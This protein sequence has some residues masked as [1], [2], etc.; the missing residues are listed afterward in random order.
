MD[1]NGHALSLARRKRAYRE[2]IAKADI[3]HADGG[4][5]VTLSHKLKGAK[6]PERSATTDMIHD[7]AARFAA[8]GHSFFLLGADEA[9]NAEAARRLAEM[10]PGLRIAGRHH[11]YFTDD[12]EATMVAAINASGADVVWLG[13]GK[14][15]EQA[16]SLRLRDHVSASWIITC[17]GCF[18][19]ITGAYPRAPQWMQNANLEWLH[20]LATNPRK[21]LWRYVVTTPHALWIALIGSFTLKGE[22]N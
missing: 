15:R 6:I 16:V 5:L 19:Y 14:P 8:T 7:F 18:N 1:V 3:V 22:M 17:G 12:D 2:M 21:L 4:F 11:G 10:Y 9:T 20:R 13:L